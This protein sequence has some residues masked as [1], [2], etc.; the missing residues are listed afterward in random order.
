MEDVVGKLVDAGG[1]QNCYFVQGTSSESVQRQIVA[2]AKVHAVPLYQVLLATAAPIATN[3]SNEKADAPNETLIRLDGIVEWSDVT[4]KPCWVMVDLQ[5]CSKGRLDEAVL[6]QLRSAAVGVLCA[7]TNDCNAKFRWVIVAKATQWAQLPRLVVHLSSQARGKWSVADVDEQILREETIEEYADYEECEDATGEVAQLQE[8]VFNSVSTITQLVYRDCYGQGASFLR[9]MRDPLKFN[10]VVSTLDMYHSHCGDIAGYA[11]PTVLHSSRKLQRINLEECSLTDVGVALLAA[12]LRTNPYVT[13]LCLA[14]NPGIGDTGLLALAAALGAGTSCRMEALDLSSNN[15]LYTE[16]KQWSASALNALWDS[17]GQ[18]HN[19]A[20]VSMSSCG[21]LSNHIREAARRW[22]CS[23]TLKRLVL[24]DNSIGDV[25][26]AMVID[27]ARSVSYLDLSH[28]GV[29]AAGFAAVG[30]GCSRENSSLE[31]VLLDSNNALALH[32]LDDGDLIGLSDEMR[33]AVKEAAPGK[34]VEYLVNCLR[35]NHTLKTLGLS[36]VNVGDVGVTMLCDLLVNGQCGLTSLDISNNCNIEEDS[37]H[38]VKELLCGGYFD[39]AQSSSRPSVPLRRLAIAGNSTN[40]GE[41]ALLAMTRNRGL[42]Y[43]SVADMALVDAMLLPLAES[44]VTN[45]YFNLT[46]LDI[47]RNF[48]FMDS[49]R[50]LSAVVKN[51]RILRVSLADTWHKFT[52]EAGRESSL[53]RTRDKGLYFLRPLIDAVGST[54]NPSLTELDLSHNDVCD[55][56][57]RE[58]FNALCNNTTVRYLLLCGNPISEEVLGLDKRFVRDYG[59][60]RHW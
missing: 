26:A 20:S 52:D 15:S 31:T 41:R 59:Q 10:L 50:S 39:E 38:K 53:S 55:E 49:V 8:D 4:K 32:A 25:G 47:G 27:A 34:A 1:P 54:P 46:S 2:S 23:N 22:L 24:S 28:T 51:S 60:L 57:G 45:P 37:A 44:V 56:V 35:E 7:R 33:T 21:L 40:I 13:E 17:F 11:L 58:F 29:G 9:A 43:L 42:E 16:E 19:I 36:R 14:R 30:L 5:G 18:N 48:L 6:H 3:T 12:A